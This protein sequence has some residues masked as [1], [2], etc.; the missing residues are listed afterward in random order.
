MSAFKKIVMIGAGNVGYHLGVRL[1]EKGFEITQVFSRKEKDAKKLAKNTSAKYTTKFAEIQPDADLYIIPVS[2]NAIASV[3]EQLS[4][5]IPENAVVVHTSGATPSKTLKPYFEKFGVLYPLQTIRINSKPDFRTLP[6]CIDASDDKVLKKL[7]K[8]AK[9][10]SSKVHRIDDQQRAV[11][12][13]AAVFVNNFGNHLFTIAADILEKEN[14]PFELLH[15]LILETAA[16]LKHH[17][18]TENQ[19][20]PAIRSDENTIKRHL[21]FLEKFPEYRALYLAFSKSINPKFGH[22]E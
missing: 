15:P 8:L 4:S 12:H 22:L 13:V 2:D 11:L 3:A 6:V 16:K 21:E 17:S 5:I 18:P 9:K 7:R 1:Y 19:T 20:G 10:I 14:L